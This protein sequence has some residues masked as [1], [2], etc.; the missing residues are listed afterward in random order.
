MSGRTIDLLESPKPFHFS[1]G[2]SEGLNFLK[3]FQLDTKLS[4][5]RLNSL[6]FGKM[7]IGALQNGLRYLVYKKT[8]F[9]VGEQ[10]NEELYIIMR[11]IYLQYSENKE[12][13]IVEQ[14]KSLNK[15]VLDYVVPTVISE[16]RM[17]ELYKKNIS[18]LPEP[19]DHSINVNSKGSKQLPSVIL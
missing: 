12:T 19:L 14:I 6:F 10:S 15:K 1:S 3:N 13:K 9:M 18:T 5:N 8:G 11:S 16:L 17:Y 7:N 2:N 4:L